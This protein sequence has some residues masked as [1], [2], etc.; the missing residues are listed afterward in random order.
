MRAVVFS[1]GFGHAVWKKKIDGVLYKVGWIPCGGYVA[2]PQM[3]P[4]G[5]TMEDEEGK[6]VP[7]PK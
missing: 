6:T 4:G 5:G 1:I 3:E 2:L 7:L